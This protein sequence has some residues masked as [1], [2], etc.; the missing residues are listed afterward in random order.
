[1]NVFKIEEFSNIEISD[2]FIRINHSVGS[3]DIKYE[4]NFTLAQLSDCLQWIVNDIETWDGRWSSNWE[5]GFTVAIE[6]D[7]TEDHANLCMS[8]GYVY[9]TIGMKQFELPNLIQFFLLNHK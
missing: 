5:H 6:F 1:M 7:K 8:C 2:G 9:I 4:G 3:T